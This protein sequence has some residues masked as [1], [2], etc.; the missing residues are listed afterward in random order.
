MALRFPA[1]SPTHTPTHRP[2]AQGGKL[3]P[4]TRADVVH[5]VKLGRRELLWYEVSQVQLG[6]WA[7]V[8]PVRAEGH[9]GSGSFFGMR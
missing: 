5:L 8:G 2:P 7:G 1:H 3:T 9:A 4:S 6:G